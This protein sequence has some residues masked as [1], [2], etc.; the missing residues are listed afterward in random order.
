MNGVHAGVMSRQIGDDLSGSVGR[1]VIDDQHVEIEVQFQQAL[2]QRRDV[3]RFIICGNN[4]EYLHGS[5][6]TVEFLEEKPAPKERNVFL[7]VLRV[8]C[9]KAFLGGRW[10]G[11]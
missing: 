10:L 11:S 4:S 5:R 7:C 6:F 9:M 8:L 3:L 1:I 2:D